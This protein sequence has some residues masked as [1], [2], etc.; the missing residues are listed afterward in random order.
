MREEYF[1]SKLEYEIERDVINNA[2][3]MLRQKTKL[4]DREN[5]KKK[6]IEER[7]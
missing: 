4:E 3:W 2:D 7:K 1:K 5:L 6:I